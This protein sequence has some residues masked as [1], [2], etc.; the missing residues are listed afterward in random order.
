[1]RKRLRAAGGGLLA[2]AAVVTLAACGSS[3]PTVSSSAFITKCK[4]DPN[5]NSAASKTFGSSKIDGLCHCV[6][7]KLVAGGFG[8]RTTADNSADVRAAARNAGI[9]CAQKILSGG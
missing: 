6:Q 2:V 7:N 4:N 5:L 3:N 9:A 8:N 1:M